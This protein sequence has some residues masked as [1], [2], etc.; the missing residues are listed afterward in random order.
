MTNP[1]KRIKVLV[2]DS[3]A[4]VRETIGEILQSDPAFETIGITSNPF[5]AARRIG[6][7]I[8]DVIILDALT[9]RMDGITFLRRLMQQCPLPVIVS[10][11][12]GPDAE[13]LERKA[14]AAGAVDILFKNDSG[15]AE[16]LRERSTEILKTLKNAAMLKSEALSDKLRTLQIHNMPHHKLTADVVLPPRSKHSAMVHTEQVICF[17]ASTGGTEALC[18]IL[19]RLS[20]D[21]P[22]ILIVQHMPAKFTNSFA[23][24]LN[25]MC[26]MEVREA[27]D[28]DIVHSGLALIAPGGM[29]MLLERQQT[30]YH[31]EI[32]RG[33]PVT[34]HCP[35]VDVLFRSAARAAGDNAIGFLLTG[36]GDDGAQGLL[37]MREAGAR[38][39]AQDEA[40]SV[41]FGMP[42]EAIKRD[43]A[44]KVLPL[45]RIPEE[46]LLVMQSAAEKR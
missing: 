39:F 1:E 33:P 20:A 30:A 29:H 35:S 2:V 25:D 37:E 45:D 3:S 40:T 19:S 42:R 24:R 36:M 4:L 46:I 11:T 38:T 23:K 18:A 9:Q 21:T 13:D 41:V 44:E 8:P 28:G 26:A 12:E 5:G 15:V 16:G 10:I 34:R 43:A 31:V 14:L 17:G 32:K 22:A 6:N 27:A 7:N